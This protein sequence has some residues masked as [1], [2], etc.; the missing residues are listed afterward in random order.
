VKTRKVLQEEIKMKNVKHELT[1]ICALF[2]FASLLTGC[3]SNVYI[4]YS[5]LSETQEYGSVVVKLSEPMQKV[6]VTLDDNIVVE[7]KHTKRV[8]IDQVPV[9]KRSVNVIAEGSNRKEALNKTLDVVV[10]PNQ[11]KM[12]LLD[13]PSYSTG[14]YVYLAV[15]AVV[16][17]VPWWIIRSKN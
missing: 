17:A 1:F 12:L 8:Q 6:N 11:T 9:G 5:G 13:V 14:Y 15:A 10:E 2:V 7:D 4:K 3:A 16:A